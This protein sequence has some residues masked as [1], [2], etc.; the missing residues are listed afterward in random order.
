MV[1]AMVKESPRGGVPVAGVAPPSRLHP[2]HAD[3]SQQ[4]TFAHDINNPLA[5]VTTNLDFVLDELE[6]GRCGEGFHA[7]IRDARDA[8]ERIATL[9]DGFRT[10]SN[11]P[12]EAPLS[13][14]VG[15]A[16]PKGGSGSL[17]GMA[18]ILIVD[19]E[20]SLGAALRRCL[21]DYDV[22]VT[23]SGQEAMAQ[24]TKGERFDVI[25][26]DVTM[27]KM[28]GDELYAEIQRVVPEQVER[29]VFITG[30]A[31]TERTRKFI[32]TV[33]NPVV[34]KPFDVNKLREMIRT[35]IRARVR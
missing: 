17:S 27:P 21:R 35:R 30:G 20:P 5:I 16:G 8:A 2:V 3:D 23:V 19:D 6:A 34:D 22:V 26:C 10:R 25:L 14:I 31:M 7:A 33:P 12:D 4:A 32:A 1:L 24:L 11:Q 29:I 13:S 28:S 18:R 9:A 15:L